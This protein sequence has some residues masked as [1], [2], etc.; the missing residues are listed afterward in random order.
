MIEKEILNNVMS[1]ALVCKFLPIQLKLNLI[2]MKSSV[3]R[4]CPK[5]TMHENHETEPKFTKH[6]IIGV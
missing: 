3:T 1:A 4:H 2:N 5:F 6:E